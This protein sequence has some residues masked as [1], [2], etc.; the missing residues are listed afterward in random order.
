MGSIAD[1]AAGSAMHGASLAAERVARPCMVDGQVAKS[2]ASVVDGWLRAGS[3]YAPIAS[4]NT[5]N[6]L[7]R[8]ILRTS[9]SE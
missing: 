1:H 3:G 2:T 8:Q 7:S 6:A 4:A 9:A 5:R